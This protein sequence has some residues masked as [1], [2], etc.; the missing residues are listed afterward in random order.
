MRVI[1]M[2]MRVHIEV[3]DQQF[4]VMS[5]HLPVM[6][7]GNRIG[8]LFGA[9][10]E[11]LRL[12]AQQCCVGHDGD[13]LPL[14]TIAGNRWRREKVPT[15]DRS[16]DLEIVFVILGARPIHIVIPGSTLARRPGMTAGS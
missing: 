14:R 10:L 13:C 15:C 1:R 2:L 8:G 16:N 3:F 12:F 6:L 7:P 9:P 4:P 5:C 11:H